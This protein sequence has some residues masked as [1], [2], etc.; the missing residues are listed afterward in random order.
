M[1]FCINGLNHNYLIKIKKIIHVTINLITFKMVIY[2][3]INYNFFHKII[4]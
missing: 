2:T 3:R 1:I 4:T